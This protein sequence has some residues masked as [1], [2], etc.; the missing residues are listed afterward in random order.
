MVHAALEN[1]RA[2]KS[3]GGVKCVADEACRFHYMWQFLGIPFRDIEIIPKS[4]L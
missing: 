3:V 4:Q 1:I 2:A